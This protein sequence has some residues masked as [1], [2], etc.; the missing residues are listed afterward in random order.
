MDE[1]VKLIPKSLR[2]KIA[3]ETNIQIE[4]EDDEPAAKPKAK[5]ACVIA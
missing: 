4:I 3:A 2:K 1:M 5:S